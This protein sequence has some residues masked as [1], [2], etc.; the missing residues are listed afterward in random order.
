MYKTD[1]LNLEL[2]YS[3]SIVANVS[4]SYRNFDTGSGCQT[5]KFP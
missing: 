4:P 5:L 2:V 1:I 3:S